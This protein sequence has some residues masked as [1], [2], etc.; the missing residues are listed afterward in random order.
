MKILVIGGSGFLGSHVSDFLSDEGHDVTIFD[1]KENPWLKDNQKIIIGDIHDDKLIEKSI[2]NSEIVY[3]FAS[4]ADID[5][6]LHKPVQTVTTNILG[7]I[8]IIDQCVKHKIKKFIFASTVYV[9]SREGGFYKCS[10]QAVEN[11]I[12]EY[13]R[14]Y[15]LQYTIFRYGS[16]YGPR[17]D[18]SNGLL[19]ILTD[20]NKNGY[21]SYQG[22]SDSEREYIHIYDAAKASC[23]AID[24]HFENESIV[25]TG[26]QHIKIVDLLKMIS[27][28]LD[29][30]SDI[31]FSNNNYEGHYIKTPY[32]FQPKLGR[33]YIPP[34]HVDLG[35]GILDLL[36]EINHP[37]EK[38]NKPN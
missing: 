21:V 34:L 13:H 10:K 28:I 35:Q 38:K 23:L 17:A 5:D 11:Y 37:D 31:Q 1:I 19:N 26:H 8:K 32:A 3:L 4:L 33:K 7:A 2:M 25:L 36:D 6:T 27:E 24:G 15:N 9:Y 12:E 22:N 30:K 16:L 14:L 18:K 29:L 20:A